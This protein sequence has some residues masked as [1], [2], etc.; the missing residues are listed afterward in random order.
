[1]WDI[2]ISHATEDKEKFVRPLAIALRAYG[3]EVWY[4][5]FTLSFGDSLSAS[6]DKGLA[7]SRFGLVVLSPHFIKKKWTRRELR[8]LIDRDVHEEKII[9]P[10]WHNVTRSEVSAFSPPLADIIALD[11]SVLKI[12]TIVEKIV[13]ATHGNS[14]ADLKRLL[15]TGISTL[16][17]ML[18]GGIP[19]PSTFSLIGK[20]GVGKSTLATQIQ[21]ASLFRGEPCIYITYR[22]SPI[23]IIDRFFRLN[24]PV[25]EFISKGILRILDN[26]SEVNGIT[27]SDLKAYFGDNELYRG[28]V[29]IE[30]PQDADNYFKK[31][32][33]LWD[34]MGTGGINVIDSVNERYAMIDSSDK[35]IHFQRFRARTKISG[36]SGIHIITEEPSLEEYN[37]AVNDIQGGSIRMYKVEDSGIMH[38]KIKIES[39]RDGKYVPFDR[40]YT[41][42]PNGLEI[43]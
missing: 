30:N 7:S 41:I 10:I 18:G 11:T 17:A 28:I 22:E 42:T 39:I 36:Q 4:D 43:F 19:R 20:K 29:R 16:D 8:G 2:F 13:I 5:E 9:L 1:M 12:S 33:E 32:L 31:Q 24:A 26:F 23:D 25:N 27:A 40:D 6:I 38:R 35:N 34:E 37:R 14:V 15:P 21:I 3:L